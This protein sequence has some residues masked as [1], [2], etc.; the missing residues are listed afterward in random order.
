MTKKQALR[1]LAFAALAL[2]MIFG[3]G[4]LLRDRSTTLAG[5]YS[6]P[7]D[8]VDVL[9]VGSSHVNS[10]IVPAV[11]WKECGISAC[12]VF[13][14]SQPIWISYYYIEEA[15]RTQKPRA[16]VLDLYGMLYGNSAE[17]PTEIDQTNYKNS[18]Q[19]DTDL[20]Y[21]RMLDTVRTCGIDLRNP[22]DFLNIVRYHTRWKYITEDMFTYDPHKDPDFMRGYGVQMGC[23]PVTV[24]AYAA[25]GAVTPPY[26]T[27]AKWLQKIVTLCRNKGV[28]PIFTLLPYGYQENECAIYNWLSAYA[29]KEKIPFLNYATVEGTRIGFDYATQMSDRGHLNEKGARAV[30]KDLGRFLQSYLTLPPAEGHA[31]AAR[32]S[33][34]AEKTYRVFRVNEE[35][36]SDAAVWFARLARDENSVVLVAAN[37]NNSAL[38][39]PFFKALESLGLAQAGQ[40]LRVPD[41]GYVAVSCGGKAQELS[42]VGTQSL[43]HTYE[44]AAGSFVLR[45][46]GNA[47]DGANIFYNGTSFFHV[48]QGIFFVLYDK[49]LERPTFYFTYDAASD[50][51]SVNDSSRAAP[52]NGT[53]AAQ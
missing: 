14:W 22:I 35:K 21:F 19:I 6:V 29:E 5:F 4:Q 7:E 1:F 41:T 42:A 8:T 12:N 17:Q 16:V 39:Q 9:C 48:P 38:P 15:L 25:V 2:W 40:A 27:A 36:S 24:P 26:D 49:V 45:S 20:T 43:Q 31:D 32:I 10:G 47:T 37:G 33:E 3:L 28:E 53:A 13:S 30:T 46:Q 50:S 18:F 51:L 23:T 52:K 11:L 34:D 44:C